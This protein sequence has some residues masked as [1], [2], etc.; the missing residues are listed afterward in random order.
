MKVLILDNGHGKN[1]PGKCSPD[2]RILEYEW[3]R[4]M[5][6]RIATKARLAGI[7]TEI[8]VPEESDIPLKERV[9]RVNTLCAKYGTQNCALISVHINAAGNGSTWLN[10]RGWT[11]WVAPKSS[12]L[13]KTLARLLY[14]EASRAG[15]QGNRLPSSACYWVGNF[16]IVRDTKCP[17]VLTENLFQDNKDDVEYLVSESGKDAIATLHIDAIKKYFEYD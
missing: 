11:G 4:N 17:A 6:G 13:S 9:R 3:T 16:A 12:Q 1:T 15:L 8:V 14:I 5:V 2:K 10:A 7:H